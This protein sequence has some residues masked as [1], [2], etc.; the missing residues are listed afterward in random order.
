MIA[1]GAC[2][3]VQAAADWPE[4]NSFVSRFVQADGRVI[5]LTF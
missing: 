4:W 5:D 3:S 1:S 2:T